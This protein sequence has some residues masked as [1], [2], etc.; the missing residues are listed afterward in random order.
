MVLGKDLQPRLSTDPHRR[1]VACVYPETKH[2]HMHR[3][4]HNSDKENSMLLI[5][6]NA[7]AVFELF[8]CL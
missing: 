3:L 5:I 1:A 7:M 8:H 2:K 4:K 6:L